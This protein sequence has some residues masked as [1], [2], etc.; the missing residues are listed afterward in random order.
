[1]PET[2]TL[3]LIAT[4][5]DGTLLNN[6]KELPKD[7]IPWVKEHKDLKIVV[8]SGRQY[9]TLLRDFEEIKDRIIF[10]SD[11]GGFAVYR[12]EIIYKD[13]MSREDTVALL[14]AME[15]I[16]GCAAI[17]CGIESAY[18]NPTGDE[19]EDQGHMYYAK[20][21]FEK[22]L[23][24]ATSHDKIIKCALYIPEFRAE[25]VY[26]NFPKLP[27]TLLPV[28]SGDSWIDIANKTVNK[29]AA[30]LAIQKRF[31]ISADECIAFGDYPNDIEML[32]A[33]T[34][35][36]CMAN[37]HDLVRKIA[38]HNAPSNEEQG[39]MQILRTL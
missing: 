4:D 27:D 12:D 31:D 33:C 11:N 38:K 15:T 35:S 8:A 23:Y 14:K 26:N 17:A 2:P 32:E 18:M 13:L 9:Y 7:F 5:M 24:E 34:E 16:P 20:I 39:V 30:L 19:A 28:L 6:A 1:M 29:G 21:R 25:E 36:Y 10:V 22:D 3:K 37:G